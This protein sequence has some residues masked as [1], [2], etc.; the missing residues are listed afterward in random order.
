MPAK[1][2]VVRQDRAHLHGAVDAATAFLDEGLN[3]IAGVHTAI[4]RK[5]FAVLRLAPGVGEVS[6]GV[7]IVHDG[8]TNLVYGSIR[9]GI[10]VA[11]AAAQFAAGLTGGGQ[12]EP[13]PGSIGDMAVAALN[14]FAGDRLARTGNGLA[15]SMNLRHRGE[16]VSIERD[17]LAAAFP[18]PSRRVAV[19]V[20]GLAC[21]ESIWCRH[22]E[23]H[24]GTPDTTYG[25]LLEAELG[26]VALY[27][28]YNT[29]LHISENGRALARLLDSFV[30]EWPTEIDELTLI[31]HSMGGLVARSACHYGH[32]AEH[33]WTRSVRHVVFL[34]S[35]HLGAPLEKAANMAAW[36]LERIDITR[37]LAVALNRRSAGIKDLRFGS[38]REE[39]WQSTDLDALLSGRSSDVPLLEGARHYFVAATVTRN[40]RHPLGVAVGDLLVREPS[41]SRPGRVRHGRFTLESGRSFG[42]MNHL[43]LLNHPDV[44]RQMQQWFGMSDRKERAGRRAPNQRRTM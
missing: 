34:G 30:S 19:F 12:A 23:R 32:E 25:S 43:D 28:R 6:E 10:G 31:G 29:G 36:G 11:G 41:A 33:G 9:A 24:Y 37:P 14:G 21:G 18:N 5:P 26:Y 38:L 1:K 13:R 3:T 39:D 22:S 8:I 4:A 2:T 40:P 17:H 44:Y 15:I 16:R 7:R 20:H 35:P 27:V 42:P